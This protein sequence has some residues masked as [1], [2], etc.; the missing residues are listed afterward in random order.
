MVVITLYFIGQMKT[1]MKVWADSSS[2]ALNEEEEG[3]RRGSAKEGAYVVSEGEWE[4]KKERRDCSSPMH[5]GLWVSLLHEMGQWESSLLTNHTA[6]SCVHVRMARVFVSGRIYVKGNQGSRAKQWEKRVGEREGALF[7]PTK[8]QM[9]GWLIL[10]KEEK[11]VNLIM[12]LQWNRV[13]V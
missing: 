7:A 3:K 2:V 10:E 4:Q 1:E 8:E 5:S 13:L 12:K 9:T 11:S 6:W